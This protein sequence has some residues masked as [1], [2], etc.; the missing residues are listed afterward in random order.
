M[1]ITVLC[2]TIEE[3]RV[4][5]LQCVRKP[6]GIHYARSISRTLYKCISAVLSGANR[7]VQTA[8]LSSGNPGLPW[9][10]QVVT[11]GQVGKPA[12]TVAEP[13]LPLLTGSDRRSDSYNFCSPRHCCAEDPSE[14]T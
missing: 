10:M 7:F 8:Q 12:A 14:F 1:H 6:Y 13:D 4:S 9:S 5:G 3:H 2:P 11:P